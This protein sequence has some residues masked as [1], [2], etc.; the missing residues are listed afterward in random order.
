MPNWQGSLSNQSGLRTLVG[1]DVNE[2]DVGR[3]EVARYGGVI[4][5]VADC[6]MAG[7]LLNREL[8]VEET[9]AA[10]AEHRKDVA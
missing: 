10:V 9:D 3:E 5:S 2:P 1:M 6:M 8:I 7:T 4:S